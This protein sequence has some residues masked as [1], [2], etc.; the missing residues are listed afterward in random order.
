MGVFGCSSIRGVCNADIGCGAKTL[1]CASVRE[2]PPTGSSERSRLVSVNSRGRNRHGAALA[3]VC[4]LSLV[5]LAGCVDD[6]TQT[7]DAG[8]A[9]VAQVGPRCA[10]LRASN[11]PESDAYDALIDLVY[12]SEDGITQG[13]G[14]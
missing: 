1:H 4:A 11:D 13:E 14:G 7:R 6:E 10:A 5:T 12:E 2:C 8:R 9:A 3:T